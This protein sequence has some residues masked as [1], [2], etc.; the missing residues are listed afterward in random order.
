MGNIGSIV[1]IIRHIGYDAEVVTTKDQVLQAKK[2]IFP[3][4]GNW[5]NG[6][7]KLEKSGLKTCN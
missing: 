3:G 6:V 7:A 5:H 1:N 2:L 4:I